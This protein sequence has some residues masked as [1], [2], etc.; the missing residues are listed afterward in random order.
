MIAVDANILVYAHRKD[1]EFHGRA[2]AVIERLARGHE[3]WAIPWTCLHEF[4]AIVS[5][6]RV[7]KIPTPIDTALEQMNEWLRSPSVR[8]LAEEA[9]YGELVTG[10]LKA[11]RVQ[12]P[13]VHDAR[14]AAI[15]LQHAVREL[16]TADRDFSRFPQLATR[17]PLLD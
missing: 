7:F 5:H 8:T 9:D 4:L 1:V 6:P 14:I 17:N 11:A 10:L 12:G 16:W 3:P 13:K 2:Y 15:C